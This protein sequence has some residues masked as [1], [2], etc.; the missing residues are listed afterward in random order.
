MA[1]RLKLYKLNVENNVFYVDNYFLW[2]L[3]IYVDNFFSY[4][5]FK[6]R[7]KFIDVGLNI[8]C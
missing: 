4:G 5:Q 8:L 1:L 6:Y 2:T 3:L 7:Q